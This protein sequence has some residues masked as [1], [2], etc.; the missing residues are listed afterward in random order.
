M[1]NA[2]PNILDASFGIICLCGH[3]VSPLVLDNLALG[4]EELKIL[5]GM[6]HDGHSEKIHE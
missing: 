3:A 6:V 2:T 5:G 1:E 4:E